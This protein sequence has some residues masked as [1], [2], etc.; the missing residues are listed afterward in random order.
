LVELCPDDDEPNEPELDSSVDDVPFSVLTQQ[1]IPEK[2][3]P[4]PVKSRV[5]PSKSTQTASK[6]ATKRGVICVNSPGRR[7]KRL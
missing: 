7:S 3:E 2:V 1:K 6:K 4:E 5:R